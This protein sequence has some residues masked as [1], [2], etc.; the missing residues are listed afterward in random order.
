M[1]LKLLVCEKCGKGFERSYAF[2][3]WK[4]ENGN[5]NY[6]R[7]CSVKCRGNGRT[8]RVLEQWEKQERWRAK[9]ARRKGLILRK[10]IKKV[11]KKQK[12][13][14]PTNKYAGKVRLDKATYGLYKINWIRE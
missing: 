7:F 4:R 14:L 3:T 1:K 10:N 6:G 8:R 5:L 11:L 13:E 12:I 9:Y 2:W